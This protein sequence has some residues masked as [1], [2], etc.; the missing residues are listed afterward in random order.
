[1]AN[2]LLVCPHYTCISRHDKDVDLCFKTS[3]RSTIQHLAFDATGLK[4]NGEAEWKV[5]EHGTDGKRRAWRKLHLAVDTDTH[6]II[7]A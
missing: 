2:F 1:M 7:A 6:E 3:S 4:V 5:K